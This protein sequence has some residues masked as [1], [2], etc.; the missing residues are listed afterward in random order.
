[1]ANNS[2][3][4]NFKINIEPKV[5]NAE[6]LNSFKQ[7]LIDLKK[8]SKDY[9]VNLNSINAALG[10]VDEILRSIPK[11]G[12]VNIQQITKL[13]N[14][15]SEMA[16][17][18]GRIHS[19][20]SNKDVT[21][22]LAKVND[23]LKDEIK[24]V[25]ELNKQLT[26]LQNKK[27]GLN[28]KIVSEASYGIRLNKKEEGT[29]R[30][31]D[32]RVESLWRKAEK[33]GKSIEEYGQA[34]E[35]SE[36]EIK[37]AIT[38]QQKYHDSF[39]KNSKS[40]KDSIKEVDNQIVELNNKL[41]IANNS[42]SNLTTQ[43][44]NLELG[45]PSEEQVAMVNTI[46][47]AN[48]E[49]IHA[50]E[51]LGNL[52]DEMK[53]TGAT[54][55]Q[56]N[57]KT[58]ESATGFKKV[59][60]AVINY[61]IVYKT[62]Q[63]LLKES[64]QTILSLDQALTDMA[65]LT[66]KSR[67]ELYALI[68]QFTELAKQTSSTITEVAELTTEYMKQG[69]TLKDSIELSEQTAKAAKI[70]R[71][72]TAESL[73][74]MTSAINGFNLAAKD[75]ERV[76][77]IFAKVGAATATDYEELAIALSKVSA[78]ANT[79]GMSIEFTT[80]LL[81]KG[82]E[83][84]QEAPESIGTALKTV[85][86]RMRELSDYGSSL[87]DNTSINKV[88]RAL[89]AVGVELR[90]T[91]GQFRDMEAIFS[92]LG[93]KWKTLNSMQQQAV[94][95]AVA[96]TRQQSRFLAIM[97]DWN[98][99]L[100]IS[101]QAEQSAGATRYQYAKQSEGLA[102]TLTRLM[103][104]WQNFIQQFTDNDLIIAGAE[105]LEN[106]IGTVNKLLTTLNGDN[107]M[108]GTITM[109]TGAFVILKGLLSRAFTPIKEAVDAVL[110]TSTAVQ[111]LAGVQNT[112][113]QELQEELTLRE[114]IVNAIDQSNKEVEKSGKLEKGLFSIITK[115][116]RDK[117]KNNKKATEQAKKELGYAGKLTPLEEK[118]V[119]EKKKQ[120]LNEI[121]LE[122]TEKKKTN[123]RKISFKKAQEEF[124][125]SK[126]AT[127]EAQKQFNIAKS[128]REALEAQRQSLEQEVDL[129]AY[130]VDNS[131][132][133]LDKK[134]E[135]EAYA[136]R[137][138][139]WEEKY[140]QL[141]EIEKQQ[142]KALTDEKNAQKNLGDAQNNQKT[143]AI[144]LTEAQNKKESSIVTKKLKQFAFSIGT[145][146]TNMA[147]AALAGVAMAAVTS[148]IGNIGGS[149]ARANLG[150]AQEKRYENAEKKSSIESLAKEYK[151]LYL[152]QSAGIANQEDSDRMKEIADQLK[153]LDPAITGENI[154]TAADNII[155]KLDEDNEKLL[156]SMAKDYQTVSSKTWN[157]KNKEYL[158]S[159]EGI[160]VFQDL[161]QYSL[162][163]SKYNGK[164][165]QETLDIIVNGI[166]YEAIVAEGKTNMTALY[167]EIAAIASSYG[168]NK[169]K[170]GDDLEKQIAAYNE[171]KKSI[172]NEEVLKVLKQNNVGLEALSNHTTTVAKLIDTGLDSSKITAFTNSMV[173]LGL[174]IEG[175]GMALKELAEQAEE[176][177]GNLMD[178]YYNLLQESYDWSDETWRDKIGAE[179][180]DSLSADERE[181]I[182]TQ[183]REQIKVLGA[184]MSLSQ[185][186]DKI[187]NLKSVKDT[188]RDVAGK[189]SSGEALDLT[190]YDILNDLGLMANEEFVQALTD[191]PG[192]AAMMI[193]KE[194][195][196]STAELESSINNAI[197]MER[198]TMDHNM[199]ELEEL[200]SIILDE[201]GQIKDSATKEQVEQYEK[202]QESI[203]LSKEEIATS[204]AKL[205]SLKN[206]VIA[207][208]V[209]LNKV[210][211]N[212]QKIAN[213]QK[214]IEKNNGGTLKNY[215]DIGNYIQD[216]INIYTQELEKEWQTLGS[217]VGLSAEAIEKL[218]VYTEEGY[219]PAIEDSVEQWA[220]ANNLT[221]D[222]AN[223]LLEHLDTIN[224]INRS[225]EEQYTLREE[226]MDAAVEAAAEYQN[227]F[228]DIIKSQYEQEAEELQ[229][230]LDERREM[231]DKYF[232]AIEGK[233]DEASYE[234]D[235]QA[236]LNRIA[237]LSTATDSASLAKLKEAQEELNTLNDE[238]NSSQREARREAVNARLDKT[239]TT[240][241][242][243]LEESL[244]NGEVL[245]KQ[246]LEELKKSNRSEQEWENYLR[247]I[248]TF[249]GMTELAIDQYMDDF[250]KNTISAAAQSSWDYQEIR[251]EASGTNSQPP[252]K[253]NKKETIEIET[254]N[255]NN[256]T[257]IGSITIGSDITSESQLRDMLH[258]L[259]YE[260]YNEILKQNGT[261][262]NLV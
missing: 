129:L 36:Q 61:S 8:N 260:L 56:L 244:A 92:E 259:F 144:A 215:K 9:G 26:T 110:K 155:N 59:A 119:K 106:I 183:Y 5:I 21:Q 14:L 32:S 257:T 136:K 55:A 137:Y 116:L 162:S 139:A 156:K 127:A 255:N 6:S 175:I 109:L 98:R 47:D 7:T 165:A 214:Q 85:L 13:K 52:K 179:K 76:S 169:A 112:V 243:K 187:T 37:D 173:G 177:K 51:F 70:A 235:R 182:K 207:I 87:E 22:E 160:S 94:A 204:E 240:I 31:A 195:D 72:S 89:K 192:K 135:E 218:F 105:A 176:S 102:A 163:K 213:I 211:Q 58:S 197:K 38:L 126:Q 159:D 164:E 99:T 95:Q 104:E 17:E 138:Y 24:N 178:T 132:E 114:K 97:Q 186:G 20:L 121:K 185:T 222:Q 238:Y 82:I 228:L 15:F 220:T 100:E 118:Q 108:V 237:K 44:T 133:L 150:Q 115:R 149:T 227:Y 33:Q 258:S 88:E 242:K 42:I 153:E 158:T 256:T 128:N 151:E 91:N 4:K 170:A 48:T 184:G 117:I 54:T 69:R 252:I 233:E 143:K 262:P 67:E 124:D 245:W 23:S 201:N 78:Q 18:T 161:A 239:S 62:F 93:P 2:K 200:K 157:K 209:Q 140:D 134:A 120:L 142:E 68:P 11:S 45:T 66:G 167:E 223:Y 226:N 193:L 64:I 261:N 50:K 205:K 145:A 28:K 206:E 231:Y 65:M 210:A 81:A 148:L 234:S 40:L 174:S 113:N 202:L 90:D 146:L 111:Q 46:N 3:T 154:L 191:N 253:K 39:I 123:S 73:E 84:T 86:A 249:D 203:K 196:S 152:K 241:D 188:S 181:A 107:G 96:G 35:Y 130:K 30:K 221:A 217:V 53:Q 19:Q 101:Q 122:Q 180:W 212:N 1:M 250:M 171:A 79:A 141:R 225:L 103:T 208:N 254:I 57:K 77:D 198:S 166:D 10:T 251:E 147:T 74:Y 71:I 172:K 63:R 168:E 125:T 49:A 12:I 199:Q 29:G 219:V 131:E 224:D 83:T 216:N 194:L 34:N 232:D 189:L 16:D 80:A 230:S 190:D 27:N 247:S 41:T 25:E 75:A 229:K 236:L 248:G 60:N 43:K 246:M